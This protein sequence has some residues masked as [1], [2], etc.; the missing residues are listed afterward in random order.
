MSAQHEARSNWTRRSGRKSA[1]E[2]VH[3]FTSA[4]NRSIRT[5]MTPFLAALTD[6]RALS[7]HRYPSVEA[8]IPRRSVAD[9]TGRCG[10]FRDPQ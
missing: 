8:V 2:N 5:T 1:G 10:P 3:R 7:H 4:W 6:R 9:N